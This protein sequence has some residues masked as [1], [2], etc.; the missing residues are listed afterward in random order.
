MMTFSDIAILTTVIPNLTVIGSGII[1]STSLVTHAE[2]KESQTFLFPFP[3]K[4]S[5]NTV[6]MSRN[7]EDTLCVGRGQVDHNLTHTH[8]GRCAVRN[9]NAD[10]IIIKQT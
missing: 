5:N 2:V 8:T 4:L 6:T 1:K 10:K 7:T 3:F 9:T